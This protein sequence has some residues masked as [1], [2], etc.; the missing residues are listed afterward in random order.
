MK[1]YTGDNRR[2]ISFPVG[3]IG[4]GCIGLDGTGRLVDWEIFNRPNKGSLNGFSHFGI[5]AEADGKTVDARVMNSDYLGSYMG[6]YKESGGHSGYGYGPDRE[7]LCGAPHFRD[8]E[9]AGEFP[10]A[11]INFID[12]SFPGAVG[13]EAF[14][15]MIPSNE[16]DSSLPAAFYTA[17]VKNTS[18]RALRYT[19]E[20]TLNNPSRGG[21]VHRDASAAH[22]RGI[23]LANV[24]DDVIAPEGG[25]LICAVP[26]DAEMQ[27]QHYWYR[28]NW[29]DNLGVFWQDFTA[30]GAL[31]DR[32]YGPAEKYVSD[33]ATIAVARLVQPGE[34]WRQRFLIG[35]Y[36]PN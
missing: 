31:R 10:M 32:V 4:S 30:P 34:T 14:N 5:K 23:E 13:L 21:H 2:E 33:L 15:P 25:S 3:G 27:A 6:R 8:A 12:E 9:F 29:F 35:W 26:A 36:Y 7:L 22:F 20:L 1:I 17:E 24:S 19:F 11:R 28:G 16:D 18:D